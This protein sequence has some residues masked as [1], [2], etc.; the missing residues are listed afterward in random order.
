MTWVRNE[1]TSRAGAADGCELTNTLVLGWNTGP[2]PQLQARTQLLRRLSNLC[3]VSLPLQLA[4]FIT[5]KA[6]HWFVP[7]SLKVFINAVVPDIHISAEA[8][9]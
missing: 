3:S 1:A 9:G 6:T 8:T 4:V 5:N 7:F 2:L